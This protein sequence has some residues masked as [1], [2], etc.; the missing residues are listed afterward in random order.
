MQGSNWIASNWW[1]ITL[2]AVLVVGYIVVLANTVKE[3]RELK[4]EVAKLKENHQAHIAA[5]GLHRGPDFELRMMNI[6]QQLSN[7]GKLVHVISDDV[8]DVLRLSKN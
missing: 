5:S 2:A 4:M 7:V 3:T 8:K 1:Q 6:E